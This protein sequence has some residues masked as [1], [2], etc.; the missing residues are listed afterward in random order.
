MMGFEEITGGP[1]IILVP[2]YND[3]EV[4][5]LLVQWLDEKLAE[6]DLKCNILLVDDGSTSRDDR[7]WTGRRYRAVLTIE[8]L[9]LSR[10]LGHQRAIAVGLAFVQQKKPCRA[11]V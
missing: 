2:V 11:V 6:S 5:E 1:I 4:V 8:I 10:N 3:W 7:R 9:E